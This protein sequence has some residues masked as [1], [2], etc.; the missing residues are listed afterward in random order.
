M[1]GRLGLAWKDK[2]SGAFEKKSGLANCCHCAREVPQAKSWP[3]PARVPTTGKPVM[4]IGAARGRIRRAPAPALGRTSGK[5]C[6]ITPECA[7]DP[8]LPNPSPARGEGLK[9]SDVQLRLASAGPL[10]SAQPWHCRMPCYTGAAVSAPASSS[11]TVS[12]GRRFMRGMGVQR[13]P[14]TPEGL[15]F[16]PL[17]DPD[18]PARFQSV[19]SQDRNTA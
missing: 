13:S 12:A 18:V 19:H 1:T 14:D 5:S 10:P 9:R 6:R 17:R 15:H 3:Q 11:R 8:P 7:V 16:S 4:R 2:V